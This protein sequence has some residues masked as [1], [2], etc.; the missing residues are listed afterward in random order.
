MIEKITLNAA[1]RSETEILHYLTNTGPS[2]FLEDVNV[3]DLIDTGRYFL[4]TG[5]TNAN[6]YSYLIV[7]KVAYHTTQILYQP[8]F[9][10]IKCRNKRNGEW[11]AWK[12]I[13]V[14]NG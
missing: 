6:D 4:G 12:S 5:I 10:Y 9:A 7:L 3:D 14:V 8:S 1:L 13:T 2:E 11:T